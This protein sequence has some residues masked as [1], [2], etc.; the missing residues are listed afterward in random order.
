MSVKTMSPSYDKFIKIA[1]LFLIA[2]GFWPFKITDN[3]IRAKFYRIYCKFQT[4]TYVT[5]IVSLLLNIMVLVMN[6]EDGTRIFAAINVFV[7]LFESCVKIVIF[8]VKKIPDMFEHVMRNERY[9]NESNDQ[10]IEF[11]YKDQVNY[12]RK[13]N[14]TQFVVTV[15]S[16]IPFTAFPLREALL[17]Q[18]FSE[19]KNKPF[20]HDLWYPFRRENHMYWV[21]FIN[22]LMI[23]QGTCF[24]T[25][26]QSTFI[27]L[28]MYANSRFKILNIKLRKFDRIAREEENGDVLGTVKKLI[29]EHQ[30]L[31]RFV[32][33]L[34]DRT[35]YV[36][37]MEFV[38]N[39]LSL[40]SGLLQLVV[41]TTLPQLYV[42]FTIII[43]QLSQ[44]FI[45]AWSA[46]EITVEALKVADAANAS[47]WQD[48]SSEMKQLFLMVIMRA[49][50]P[51]ALTAGDFF[52]M[53]TNTAVT[54]VKA[55]YTYL[56]V[57]L[58]NLED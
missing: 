41:I 28:M 18:D 35:K 44:I 31:I 38:L 14:I 25:A 42:V 48:Q 32:N 4:T 6:N 7:M 3:P 43:M 24:N 16:A 53:S 50:V 17:S 36:M 5:Y 34:N 52:E 20:M 19:Y 46:N 15:F 58:N 26:T 11:C 56:S 21:I 27:N 1:K 51:I 12:A 55:A 10:E 49:Q 33:S 13:V 37:L 40:A 39:A 9:V 8:Q 29:V 45:L 57:M 54:T 30:E 22:V 47:N 2:G 23:T